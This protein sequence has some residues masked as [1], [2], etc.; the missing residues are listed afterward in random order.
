MA[1]PPRHS[2]N[3]AATNTLEKTIA[4]LCLLLAY[5]PLQLYGTQQQLS[6]TT[7]PTTSLT[8]NLR[9]VN[10]KIHLVLSYKLVIIIYT[11]IIGYG[12]LD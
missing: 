12:P 9:A 1:H 10:N 5:S 11:T 6:P 4:S 8:L 3:Q 2:Y 7:L